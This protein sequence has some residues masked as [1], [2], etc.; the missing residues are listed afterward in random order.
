MKMA[1]LMVT[2]A[3][4]LGFAR[5][6]FATVGKFCSGFSDLVVAVP[7]PDVA[8]FESAA[9]PH[10]FRV[11]GFDERPGKGFLHHEAMICQADL[12]CP[13]ADYILHQD[14]DCMFTAPVTPET[15]LRDGKPIVLR[16]PYEDFRDKANRYS[17]KA[18][19]RNATGIDP[20]WETMVR[21]PNVHRREIYGVTRQ[22][23]AEHTQMD[24]LEYVLSCRNT[25]PQTFA[26]FPTLGAVAI[27][28]CE[29]AYS[30]VNFENGRWDPP[31]V[32]DCHMV[33]LWSHGGLQMKNDRHPNHTALE[34]IESILAGRGMPR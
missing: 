19:V 15:Y 13:A 12:L 21:H 27:R 18:C 6:A 33:S 9:H 11:V 28:C 22:L 32:P 31:H 29:G 4:D 17:W 1:I 5:Y 30:W 34:V 16:Q 7:T 2:F 14:A 20:H 25:Y 23:I 24:W 26:E 10:G 3:R 8:A